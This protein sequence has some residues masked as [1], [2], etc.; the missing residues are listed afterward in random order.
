MVFHFYG[1][2]LSKLSW[3]T[4]VLGTCDQSIKPNNTSHN[5][6]HFTAEV[7]SLAQGQP[8]AGVLG[9]AGLGWAGLGWAGLGWC[10]AAWLCVQCGGGAGWRQQSSARPHQRSSTVAPQPPQRDIHTNTSFSHQ[11]Q[12]HHS[13]GEWHYPPIHH[14]Q[15]Q[16]Q[17]PQLGGAGR[18]CCSATQAEVSRQRCAAPSNHG[19]LLDI[20]R[21]K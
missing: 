7:L 4:K 5:S 1:Q 17:L 11:Q 19:T 14:Q 16:L 20:G 18:A 13:N 9:W 3:L 15:Q 21:G 12:Q 8:R 6:S 10:W 2:K